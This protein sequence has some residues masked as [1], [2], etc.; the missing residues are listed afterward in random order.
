M[1]TVRDLTAEAKGSDVGPCGHAH[2]RLL[3]ARGEARYLRCGCGT[4]I[5]AQGGRTWVL[6][7]APT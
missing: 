7:P 5:V 3:S 2:K 6:R 1:A 4:L